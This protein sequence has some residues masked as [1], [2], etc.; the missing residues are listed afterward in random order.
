[1]D[2]KQAINEI[3]TAQ[4]SEITEHIFY[5]KLARSVKDAHNKEILLRISQDEL[6]HYNLWK[7]YTG[8][9]EKPDWLKIWG[10][11]LVAKVFGLMFGLKAMEIGEGRA[12]VNY[13]NISSIVPQALEIAREEAEHEDRL[14]EMIDEERL[15][16]IGSVVRGL[17]DALI[18][19][20][21]VLAGLTL[22]LG[23]PR[24]I[25]T[26]GLITGLAGSMSMAASEYL[27]SKTE[28]GS[29]APLKSALYTGVAYV[30]TVLFLVF[31]YLVLPNV[32]L[33]MG[34]M[35]VNAIIV[36]TAFNF[37]FSV[38]RSLSFWT[39]FFEMALLAIGIA[40]VS[41]GIGFIVRQAL[42]VDV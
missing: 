17:N 42:G 4:R 26:A 36:I 30:F 32:Y 35:M 10:Y 12:Q 9:V 25:A 5:K 22:A 37:Y 7:N 40:A 34:I 6:R 15:N 29:K 1:M 11:Y 8:I 16:Y 13:H 38:A 39:R 18:E 41:Y 28:G 2:K 33:S 27:A 20:T 23:E 3:K 14:I 21:G 24:L 19:L 31:P